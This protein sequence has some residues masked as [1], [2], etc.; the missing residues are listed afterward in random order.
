MCPP[1][2]ANAQYADAC[3]FDCH[4]HSVY[5][6]TYLPRR[7]CVVRAWAWVCVWAQVAG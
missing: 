5:L 1:K 6:R 2:G 7:V 4:H 3:G